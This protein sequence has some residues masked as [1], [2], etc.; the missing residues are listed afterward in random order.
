MLRAGALQ[1]KGALQLMS[2]PLIF[3]HDTTEMK[4]SQISKA[5][6]RN[7]RR[8]K[9]E[10]KRKGKMCTKRCG[11]RKVG[12]IQEMDVWEEASERAS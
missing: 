6:I 12:V 5:S 9:E 3:Q 8:E 7:R 2:T 10:K 1:C 11:G 4:S